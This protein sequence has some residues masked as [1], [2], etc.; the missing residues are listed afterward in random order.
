MHLIR[1]QIGQGSVTFL[2]TDAAFKHMNA[3]FLFL[4]KWL[5]ALV[6]LS[7]AQAKLKCPQWERFVS[8]I[9]HT[10]NI[11]QYFYI[12]L[13]CP[14]LVSDHACLFLDT[15]IRQPLHLYPGKHQLC[16][17]LPVG[18][19]DAGGQGVNSSFSRCCVG[20]LNSRAIYRLHGHLSF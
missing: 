14:S 2:K 11:P 9:L 17:I 8:E 10:E 12:I 7:K 5:L 3:A 18:D 13:V 4:L 19:R 15:S 16:L 1:W 6:C 20:C